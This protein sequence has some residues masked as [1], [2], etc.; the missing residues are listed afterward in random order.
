MILRFIY[1]FLFFN[2]AY[3][4]RKDADT[5]SFLSFNKPLSRTKI[6]K[7]HTQEDKE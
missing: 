1:T 2:T 3:K 7:Y 4:Y 6:K 5:I